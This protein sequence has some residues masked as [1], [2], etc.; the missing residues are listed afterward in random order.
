MLLVLFTSVERFR[1]TIFAPRRKTAASGT[2]GV[3]EHRER[4]HGD[5]PLGLP[6][7]DVDR[8]GLR[9]RGARA[10]FSN[11]V[12]RPTATDDIVT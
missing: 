2:D 1:A 3:R 5:C 11:A 12:P 4:D 6:G 9:L 7:D 10:L 8:F